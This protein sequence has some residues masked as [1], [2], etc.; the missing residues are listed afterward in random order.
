V[1][2]TKNSMESNYLII[3]GRIIVNQLLYLNGMTDHMITRRLLISNLQLD[4]H[5]LIS[6]LTNTEEWLKHIGNRH[7]NTPNDAKTYIQHIIDHPDRNYWTVKLKAGHT[8]IGLITY[9][10]RDNFEYHDFGFAFL[11][12]HMHMG[13]AYEASTAVLASI[14][15]NTSATKILAIT[16]AANAPSAKLLQKLGFVFDHESEHDDRKLMVYAID[17]CKDRSLI[18]EVIT[19]FFS[20]FNNVESKPLHLEKIYE[21]C[22]PQTVII[23]K[24]RE[25]EEL[26]DLK[27]FIAPRKTILSDGTLR[28]F[29][30]D[31]VAATTKVSGHL[32]Q[33]FSTYQKKG[34]LNGTPFEGSGR[35]MFQLLKTSKGWKITSVIWED[36]E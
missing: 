36:D 4:D 31:E 33:R 18:D 19:S 20:L 21:L 8:P 16:A 10:K 24:Y 6:E 28:Q 3:D 32:A 30:E 15:R 35:K 12:S 26:Y 13:Y 22:L 25:S 34:L 17:V 2:T 27:T 1:L 23:K 9:V 14:N 29:E 7:I 5:P 11:P